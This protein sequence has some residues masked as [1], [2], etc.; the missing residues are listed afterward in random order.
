M[1]KRGLFL[2]MSLMALTGCAGSSSLLK[3][4]TTSTRTDV[5]GEPT[6]GGLP[7]R[8]YTDLHI[9]AALKTHKP[10]IYS[11]SDIH[12]TKE[13]ALLVNIDGQAVLMRGS[14]QEENSEPSGIQD[15]EAGEGIRYRFYKDIRL[16]TGK[17]RIVVGLP[18]DGIAV[19][20][21]MPL[22]EGGA[23]QLTVEPKYGRKPGTGRPSGYGT[24]SFSE[25]IRSVRL[26]LNGRQM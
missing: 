18:G 3:A 23:N 7:P 26:V 16:R 6:K 19:E 8:G 21:E 17:H 14:L 4:N 9:A 22:L 1:K 24:T 20:T 2:V 11:A 12:G 5:F 25:G 13:Y 10:G 15:P